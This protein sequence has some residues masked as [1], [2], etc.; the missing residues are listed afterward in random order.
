ML[1]KDDLR[2]LEDLI[3]RAQ[4]EYRPVNKGELEKAS[5]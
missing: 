1:T 3:D 4:D 2:K 5:S